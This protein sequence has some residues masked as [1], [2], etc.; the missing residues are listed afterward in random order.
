MF[1]ACVQPDAHF[2]TDTDEIKMPTVDFDVSISPNF[3]VE[4][5]FVPFFH[6]GNLSKS[7]VDAEGENLDDVTIIVDSM[8]I[9]LTWTYP[10]HPNLYVA[11]IALIIKP[12]SDFDASI[13]QRDITGLVFESDA[14]SS[15]GVRE[16]MPLNIRLHTIPNEYLAGG[17]IPATYDRNRCHFDDAYGSNQLLFRLPIRFGVYYG[18]YAGVIIKSIRFAY[19]NLEF[20][21][22]IQIIEHLTDRDVIHNFSNPADFLA[23]FTDPYSDLSLQ[24]TFNSLKDAELVADTIVVDFALLDDPTHI[25]T[26]F[27]GSVVFANR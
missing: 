12:T 13:L 26:V 18:S 16:V 24:C 17:D 22:D 10:A 8:A 3:G 20:S 1:T 5:I 9:S 6:G 4:W 11:L 14:P 19:G 7:V 23:S 25:F 2:S 21:G 15:Y 27:G